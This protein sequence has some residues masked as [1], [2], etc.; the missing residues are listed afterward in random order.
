MP[1]DIPRF[2]TLA[3]RHIAWMLTAPQLVNI[4]QRFDPAIHVSE[5]VLD[6]L[7]HWDDHP[8][9]LPPALI[10]PVPRR[11]GLYFEQLYAVVM[12]D[13]LGWELLA[14]NLPI[15]SGGQTLG[16]LDFLLR[17]PHNGAVEHHEIAVKFYLGHRD[18]GQGDTMWYGPD[19]RDRLDIKTRRL[20]E[21]Q[22]R[23]TERPET[24]E[25]LES[26]DIHPPITPRIFMPGYL[27]YPVDTDLDSPPGAAMD[28]L[29][30]HWAHIEDALSM[31]TR[32]WVALEKPHWLGPWV[33][34]EAPDPDQSDHVLRHIQ[35]RHSPRLFAELEPKRDEHK[36]V[37]KTR[38]FVVPGPWPEH[39]QRPPVQE[40]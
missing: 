37:E 28:H 11:L 36:W 7:R 26:L 29:R 5:D 18:P 12:S 23:L 31:D 39:R 20:L 15:R 33:Q 30:G 25:V 1:P 17:N 13:L 19:C 4:V 22:S 3:L 32:H 10:Q 27:F 40:D 2:K 24:L 9:T 21:H 16:E 38:Y 8:E 35:A 14:R 6:T 34:V